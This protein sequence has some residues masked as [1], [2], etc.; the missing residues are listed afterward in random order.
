MSDGGFGG[1]EAKGD[2]ACALGGTRD[3]AYVFVCLLR[4]RTSVRAPFRSAWSTRLQYL[5]RGVPSVTY[6]A[7]VLLKLEAIDRSDEAHLGTF[8]VLLLGCVYAGFVAIV[9]FGVRS[10]RPP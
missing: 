1:D 5:R 7:G 10:W 3:C 4:R 8:L 6:F 9:A 2:C